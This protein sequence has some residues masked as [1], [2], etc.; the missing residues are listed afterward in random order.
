MPNE[1]AVLVAD[2]TQAA[3]QTFEGGYF[4]AGPVVAAGGDCDVAMAVLMSAGA[5]D[6]NGGIVGLG[7][8]GVGVGGLLSFLH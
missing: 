7:T 8:A 6:G 1:E 3:G 2:G 4:V 5:D